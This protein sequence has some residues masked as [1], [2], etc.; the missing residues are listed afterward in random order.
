MNQQQNTIHC[1][2]A[3]CAGCGDK[4]EEGAFFELGLPLCLICHLDDSLK[5]RKYTTPKEE[6][7]E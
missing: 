3:R 4:L 7:V 6:K 5:L 2:F 1:L